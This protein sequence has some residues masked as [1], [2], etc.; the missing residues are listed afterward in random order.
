MDNKE[1]KQ[2]IE[3]VCRTSTQ[4]KEYYENNEKLVEAL[5]NVQHTIKSTHFIKYYSSH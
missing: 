1:I 3:L 5:N 2:G 4:I